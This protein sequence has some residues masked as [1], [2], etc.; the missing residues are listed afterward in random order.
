MDF[1][2][3]S[4]LYRAYRGRAENRLKPAA[5]GAFKALHRE[6]Q[7]QGKRALRARKRRASMLC[8]SGCAGFA[9]SMLPVLKAMRPAPLHA[10]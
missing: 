5:R 9:A 8:H 6:G 1:Q 2:K 7:H 3:V 10:R 4:R